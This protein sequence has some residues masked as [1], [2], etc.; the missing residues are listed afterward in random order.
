MENLP[1]EVLLNKRNI[2][3]LH[4]QIKLVLVDQQKD[5]DLITRLQRQLAGTNQEL[6]LL[7]QQFF[8]M[9]ISQMGNGPTQQ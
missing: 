8:M 1:S 2:D 7:K 5:R 9:K 3:A 4:E 6:E